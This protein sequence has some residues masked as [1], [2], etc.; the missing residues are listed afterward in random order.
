MGVLIP[1][2]G[3]VIS[4]G[5]EYK[6]KNTMYPFTESWLLR[7]ISFI[8]DQ[9]VNIHRDRVWKRMIQGRMT[10]SPTNVSN[11]KCDKLR[12][13]SLA[14]L[15]ALFKLDTRNNCFGPR[16]TRDENFRQT[17][18][19]SVSDMHGG[20]GVKGKSEHQQTNGGNGVSGLSVSAADVALACRQAAARAASPGSRSIVTLTP[21]R[22]RNIDQDMHALR[23]SRQDNPYL[24]ILA[25]KENLLD[26]MDES[27]S[28][29]TTLMSQEFGDADPLTLAQVHE[30]LVRSPPPASWSITSAFH[31]PQQHEDREQIFNGRPHC[32]RAGSPRPSSALHRRV[33]TEEHHQARA[34]SACSDLRDRHSNTFSLL[35][36]TP[37]RSLSEV[38]RL[39]RSAEDSV[40]LM[41]SE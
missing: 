18:R 7:G 19:T 21:G 41:S 13:K 2:G 4:E 39:H 34:E 23:L 17:D 20:G 10:I 22:T 40:Q 5:K 11:S 3:H 26:S 8:A 33:S 24:Q 12:R 16:L 37:I 31:F 1:R 32:T 38:R 27:E 35:N 25:S 36:P 28:D 6:G 29:D 30:H 15:A 14:F 9:H